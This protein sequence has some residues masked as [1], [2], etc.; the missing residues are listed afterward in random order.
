[1]GNT[2]SNRGS[3]Q[4]LKNGGE[5]AVGSPRI[6]RRRREITVIVPTLDE[7]DNLR[8]L[9]PLL[10]WAD[11]LLVVDSFSHDGTL[12]LV[13]QHNGRVLQRE[14]GYSASQ[15]N[16][17]IPQARH[18]WIFLVDADE[19]PT[20]TLLSEIEDFRRGEG[21]AAA[22]YWIGREN[23][24]LG[25]RVLYSGWRGDRVIRLFR[26]DLCRYEDK[27]VHAEIVVDGRVGK[28]HGRLEHHT[29]RNLAHFLAKI[30]RY[31]VWSAH[32]IL[33]N[34]S[35]VGSYHLALKPA[36]RFLKHYVWQ[37]G[38]LDGKVGLIISSIMAWGVF[39][40]YAKLHEFQRV[41]GPHG[42]HESY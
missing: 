11:E 28:L 8:G 10:A 1:M 38:F 4:R 14:Y 30:E 19:R 9:L 22:A 25:E 24:F 6:D 29:C 40:R 33:P 26:R 36:F 18:E 42:S 16:W 37:G 17:A 15:K 7:E 21:D 23:Y 32:D 39:L 5:P 20:P 31:A 2:E 27:R 41:E 3:R 13:R 34:A 35:R 12:D